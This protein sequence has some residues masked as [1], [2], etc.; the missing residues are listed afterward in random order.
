MRQIPPD[1]TPEQAVEFY[2]RGWI[3]LTRHLRERQHRHLDQHEGDV[4]HLC[5]SLA[6]KYGLEESGPLIEPLDT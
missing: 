1:M 6:S 4:Y 2:R 3:N 5:Q